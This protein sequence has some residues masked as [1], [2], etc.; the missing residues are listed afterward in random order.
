[1]Q[2]TE[3]QEK[4]EKTILELIEISKTPMLNGN[5]G[6]TF[7][8]EKY[9]SR[10]DEQR[11]KSQSYIKD[12]KVQLILIEPENENNL[13]EWTEAIVNC[14]SLFDKLE[15]IQSHKLNNPIFFDALIERVKINMRATK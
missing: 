13:D 10:G 6:I 12:G 4:I 9:S 3:Q 14:F 5:F 15:K 7:I 8:E 11:R 1:M 2:R